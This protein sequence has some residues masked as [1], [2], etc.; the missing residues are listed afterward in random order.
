MRTGA[1]LSVACV[2]TFVTVVTTLRPSQAGAQDA[3]RAV[4]ARKFQARIEA[5]AGDAQGVLGVQILDLTDGARFGV[6][7][8]LVFPQGSA[9]KIP[10]LLALYARQA[11]GELDVNRRVPLRAADR[12]GGSGFLANFGD[13]TSELSLHDLAVA[14]I[15]VSDNT[16]TNMLIDQI[17]MEYVTRLMAE[18][19]AANTRL[20]RKMI[21]PE[22][23]AKG[24]ENLSTPAEAAALMARIHRCE[25]PVSKADCAEIRR[26]LEIR[27]PHP[28]PVQESAPAGV[29]VA[30]KDGWFTGVWSAWSIVGLPGRPYVL[31]AMGNY[32][33]SDTVYAAIRKVADA[34]YEYF[35]RLAGA[36][37]YGTR[38]PLD[39]L[40][41]VSRP[42]R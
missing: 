6:N 29:R 34:S 37:P 38:V 32:S 22:E 36:T 41:R 35:S 33:E 10:I 2:A 8:N 25:I 9:I 11:A 31:A 18:L 21:R 39:L 4:L 26:I 15:V 19:G 3:H 42:P 30:E 16:A 23:S 27:H 7:E 13:G 40:D 5:I 28:A 24:N 17:G 14:M 12:T 20:Q 1:A